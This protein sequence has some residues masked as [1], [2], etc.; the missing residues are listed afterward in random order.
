M[1]SRALKKMASL[2]SCT[3]FSIALLSL[4]AFP[5]SAARLSSDTCTSSNYEYNLFTDPGNAWYYRGSGGDSF[6][7]ANPQL[8]SYVC[9]VNGV[10]PC[11]I[12]KSETCQVATYPIDCAA[13]P[14]VFSVQLDSN[15]DYVVSC[16]YLD[17]GSSTPTSTSAPA[18]TG[19]STIPG[20]TLPV[21][22]LPVAA[23]PVAAP[24][25]TPASTAPSLP[26]KSP[27]V[28]I[29]PG[30]VPSPTTSTVL[31]AVVPNLLP[32][33]TDVVLTSAYAIGVVSYSCN[34]GEG[35]DGGGHHKGNVGA[36][37][38]DSLLGSYDCCGKLF[39]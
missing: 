36:H 2:R 35:S 37:C 23:T 15:C 1:C 8:G 10:K 32:K 17:S 29:G 20:G 22:T 5:A 9:G 34:R 13:A 24:L 3:L 39:G 4:F 33:P 6:C 27:V 25:V 11:S 28:T 30:T 18:S 19:G 31:P 38:D 16:E 7:T 14:R 12:T 21:G 26:T